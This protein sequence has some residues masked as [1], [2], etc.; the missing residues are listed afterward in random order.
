M[1]WAVVFLLLSTYIL[2]RSLTL[3]GE[4]AQPGQNKTL[5]KI[6]G[7]TIGLG[8]WFSAGV[9]AFITGLTTL[10]EKVILALQ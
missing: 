6:L 3:L 1:I 4:V 5:P 2:H 7:N 10:V 9:I 8:L